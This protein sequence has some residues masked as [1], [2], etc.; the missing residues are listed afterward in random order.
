MLKIR[1]K[2]CKD[3]D[4]DHA[5]SIRQ[6]AHV[7]HKPNVICVAKAF[8]KLP[9]KIRAG[10]ILHELGHLAGAD[11]EQQADRLA[12]KLFGIKVRRINSKYGHNLET[13]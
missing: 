13:I 3:S 9:S 7:G 12:T 2:H 10:L 4:K 11:G 5:K 6:Y 8:Y 1:V